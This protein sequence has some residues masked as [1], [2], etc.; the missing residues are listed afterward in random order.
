M[1]LSCV[2]HREF[3]F[4]R[5]VKMIT[6][7]IID[8]IIYAKEKAVPCREWRIRRWNT[9]CLEA[10]RYCKKKGEINGIMVF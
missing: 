1:N 7:E 6:Q 9:E 4:W 10:M 8:Y 3:R 2:I 5:R